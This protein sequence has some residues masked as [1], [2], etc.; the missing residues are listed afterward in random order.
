MPDAVAYEN[1]V[2]TM[3]GWVPDSFVDQPRGYAYEHDG[4]FIH[5]FGRHGQL[6]TISS[7]LTFFQ[8]SIG[9][10]DDWAKA[11]FGAKDNKKMSAPAGTVIDGVWRP[12]LFWEEQIFQALRVDRVIRRSAEQALHSLVER[13]SEL[14]LYIEPEGAGL[15]ATDHARVNC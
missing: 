10:L 5:L 11:N 4:R 7:G 15:T 1:T 2:T 8:Q 14:L 9:T 3:P 12:G 13:L 6:W